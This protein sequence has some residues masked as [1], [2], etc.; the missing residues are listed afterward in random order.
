MLGS[1]RY[2]EQRIRIKEDLHDLKLISAHLK[3]DGVI[4]ERYMKLNSTMRL[5]FL[6]E[7]E[8]R[9]AGIK[10]IKERE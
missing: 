4:T 9:I 2:I 7:N 3:Q 6:H 5:I 8:T 1:A 10:G